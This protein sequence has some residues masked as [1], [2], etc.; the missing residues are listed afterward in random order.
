MKVIF[1]CTALASWEGHATGIQRVVIEVGRGLKHCLPAARLGFF[2]DDGVCLEYNID[3]QHVGCSLSVDPGDIVVTA[4]S[5][6]D[7]PAHH[8]V[9]MVLAKQGV[10]LSTLFYDAIPI[11]FPYSYG[12]G[13]APIYECWLNESLV[14]SD[15]VFAISENTKH[16]LMKCA[17]LA[18]IKCPDI[19]CVRLGDH[20]SESDDAPS[21]STLARTAVPFILSV[22]TLEYRKNHITL[23]NTYRYMLEE[24]GYAPPKL[25]IVGKKGWLDHELEYQVANDP[26]LAGRIE[27]LQGLSDADLRCLY[28]RAMF[29]VY[30]SFYEGWGLPV[31]ESL[32]FGKPCIASRSSSMLEIAPGLVRHAHPLLVNEWAEQIQ[33]LADNPMLLARETERVQ[34]SYRRTSWQDTAGQMAKALVDRYPQLTEGDS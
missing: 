20:L 8:Q 31:A 28:Q 23:L 27:I 24:Q 18:G 17:N 33:A 26:R 14:T 10:R 22:S 21:E 15:F 34:Q 11:L 1:D 13:F 25:Y 29:T 5:N 3:L 30:P 6:W 7:Y 16:D 9:L 4:G 19:F 32:C 12:P 2:S